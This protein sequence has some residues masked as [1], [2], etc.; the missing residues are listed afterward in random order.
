[1]K[2]APWRLTAATTGLE[3]MNMGSISDQTIR[4]KPRPPLSLTPENTF[5]DVASKNEKASRLVQIG[6]PSG[7]EHKAEIDAASASER[8]AFIAD[9]A[10]RYNVDPDSQE[11]LDCEIVSQANQADA[12]RE[13]HRRHSRRSKHQIGG[14]EA[15]IPTDAQGLVHAEN[16]TDAANANRFVQQHGDNVRWC[17]PWGKWLVWDDRRWA[18]DEMCIV[19]GMAKDIYRGHFSLEFLQISGVVTTAF[20]A[21]R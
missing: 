19:Q 1:M 15:D 18:I 3:F 11:W 2:N 9:L 4:L 17:E 14:G 20:G 21:R 16:R 8:Q 6:L 12:G 13:Q 10:A 5:V 7:G